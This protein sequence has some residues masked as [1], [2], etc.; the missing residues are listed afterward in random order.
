[1]IVIEVRRNSIE[2]RAECGD[3]VDS[4]QQIG[5]VHHGA[6]VGRQDGPVDGG[7]VE[8]DRCPALISVRGEELRN[9]RFERFCEGGRCARLA[10][11]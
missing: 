1:M 11:G 3:F 4:Q 8:D 5:Y 10:G 2:V 7:G 9:V 6:V